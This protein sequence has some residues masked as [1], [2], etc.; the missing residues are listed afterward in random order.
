M[1]DVTIKREEYP[2]LEFDS[3]KTSIT[4][5]EILNNS[6]R[7]PENCVLCFFNDVLQQ[8]YEKGLTKII[9]NVR[10]EIGPF[11]IYEIEFNGKKVA[12]VHH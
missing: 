7:V 6:F 4:N 5:P 12:E 3:D 8:L 11:P 1:P 10:S 9:G 2:I